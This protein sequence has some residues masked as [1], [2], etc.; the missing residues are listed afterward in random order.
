[1]RPLPSLRCHFGRLRPRRGPGPVQS[2]ARESRG[3][4]DRRTRRAALRVA[5]FVLLA[6][7]LGGGAEARP[8]Y[9]VLF[10]HGL[11]SSADVW[12]DVVSDLEDLGFVRG[13]TFDVELGQSQSLDEV[14]ID[15]APCAGMASSCAGGD[16]WRMNFDTIDDSNKAAVYLQA[17]AIQL[18]VE[19]LL[20]DLATGAE[21]VLLVGHSMGG[22]AASA[23]ASGV[24]GTP[25]DLGGSGFGAAERVVRVVT[26]GSPFGGSGLANWE[27]LLGG[28]PFVDTP[29][30]IRDLAKSSPS[31]SNV[32]LSGGLEGDVGSSFFSQDV[33]CDGVEEPTQEIVGLLELART[34]WPPETEI[35]NVVGMTPDLDFV[36]DSDCVVKSEDQALLEVAVPEDEAPPFPM[37][38]KVVNAAHAENAFLCAAECWMACPVVGCTETGATNA[39]LEALD[40]SNAPAVPWL[41]RSDGPTT[42]FLTRYDH[43]GADHDYFFFSVPAGVG[44][45]QATLSFPFLPSGDPFLATG[46]GLR[47]YDA[48]FQE[49]DAAFGS[50]GVLTVEG[51]TSSSTS[52]PWLVRVE[53]TVPT[54]SASSPCGNN[55][56]TCREPYRVAVTT[57]GIGASTLSLDATPDAVEPGQPSSLLAVVRASGGQPVASGIEVQ[58]TASGG[59]SG[60]NGTPTSCTSTTNAAGEATAN[61]TPAFVGSHV[62]TATAA[63]G[64]SDTTTVIAASGGLVVNATPNPVEVDVPSTIDVTASRGDGSPAPSGQV[65]TFSTT[66]PGLFSGN[67]ASSS[68]SPSSVQIDG[69]GSTWIRFTPTAS[70]VAAITVE[71]DGADAAILQL[72]AVA[73]SN[74][75]QVQLSVGYTGGSETLAEYELEARV[76]DDDGEPIFGEPVTFTTT[77]GGLEGTSAQSVTR[78]TGPTGVADAALRVTEEVLVTV[79]A[80]A[81]GVTSATS[82]TVQLG[83]VSAEIF[84]VRTLTGF[85][86]DVYGVE[87]SPDGSLLVAADYDGNVR[88][89]NTSG[90]SLRWS[91]TTDDDRA[92]QVSF[93]PSGTKVLVGHDDAVDVFSATNGS[94]DCSASLGGGSGEEAVSAVF[95]SD[96]AF[97]H[98]SNGGS[99]TDPGFYRHGSLC[100]SGSLER[101][102]ANGDYFNI[103]AHMDY[104]DEHNWVAIGSDDGELYVLDASTGSTVHDGSI[105]SG[106][107]EAYDVDFSTDSSRLL[108]V[109]WQVIKVFNTTSWSTQSF[110]APG[111]GDDHYGAVFLDADS[112][113]AIGGAGKI[114]ILSASVGTT[115][116]TGTV[117][118]NAWEMAWSSALERLAVGT[119][120]GQVLVFDP[121]APLDSQPPIISVFAPSEGSSTDEDSVSTSGSVTDATAVSSFTIDGAPVSLDATGNF[122]T[123]VALDPGSNSITYA[124]SDPAGN[125]SEVTRNVTRLIDE[126]PPIVFGVS[127]APPS[128][129]AGFVVE[130][131]ADAE[132][133]DTGVASVTAF[134]EDVSGQVV[135]TLPMAARSPETYSATYSTSGRNPGTYTVDIEAVDSSPQANTRTLSPAGSFVVESPPDLDVTPLT[136]NFGSVLVGGTAQLAFQ[137]RNLGGGSLSG[138]ATTVP[139]FVVVSGSPFTLGGGA[140]TIVAVE[141]RPVAAGESAGTLEFTGAGQTISVGLSGA[142]YLPPA[143]LDPSVTWLD[144]GQVELFTCPQHT[145]V[146]YNVGG[147]ELAG[148]ASASS[149]FGIVGD[150]AYTI[151]AGASAPIVVEFCPSLLGAV[152]GALEL[153]G[154]GG[155]VVELRG[156]GWVPGLIF[157]SG[158]ESGAVSAWS[159]ATGID[160]SQISVAETSLDFGVIEPGSTSTGQSVTI[161]N[162]GAGPL[163]GVAST[164]PPFSVDSGTPYSLYP[165]ES[166]EVRVA[167]A[168]TSPGTYDADL[169]LTGGGGASV[170]LS[171]IGQDSSPGG[172]V[173]HFRFDGNGAD[174]SPNGHDASPEAVTWSPGVL[175][176]AVSFSTIED[177][178][179]T[180]VVLDVARPYTLAFWLR[181]EGDQVQRV[182]S[183]L[184][185]TGAGLDVHYDSADEPPMHHRLYSAG[186]S[187]VSADQALSLEEWQ[188]VAAVW[189]GTTHAS[190]YLNGVLTESAPVSGEPTTSNESVKIGALG[191]LTGRHEDLVGSVD[192]LYIYDRVLS[193]SEISDLVHQVTELAPAGLYRF[194]EGAGTVAFDDSENGNDGSLVLGATW[195]NEGASGS[196]VSFGGDARVDV[197]ASLFSGLGGTAYAR[198]WVRLDTLPL[199]FSAG[200]VYRRAHYNDFILAVNQDGS[201]R[202]D[203][204]SEDFFTGALATG[205][206]VPVGTWKKIAVWYDGTALRVFI[207]DVEAG[208][209][210]VDLTMAWPTN[211]C[212]SPIP[213]DHERGC[214]LGTSVGGSPVGNGA[215]WTSLP[216]S[217][218]EVCIADAPS[219][220]GDDVQLG[221][222]RN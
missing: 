61:F 148:S 175:G 26:L 29:N 123:T 49:V 84:P 68:T 174:S 199:S 138:T 1:M 77:H 65:V 176:Q 96:S 20:G 85:T 100:G 32:F 134:V 13:G 88:A 31:H 151:A 201:V 207:D 75:I 208:S 144:F 221:S 17:G 42:G 35:F 113:I 124:A 104:S 184:S 21:R 129:Q 152:T 162:T 200:V 155:G 40:E 206:S 52:D 179:D 190:L 167:F 73:P 171:G 111:L 70:G 168:P 43:T 11:N 57:S 185:A 118:G 23:F 196:A 109:G 146:L 212:S 132:D 28:L 202:G 140:S 182:V 220:C 157:F 18:A 62:V 187:V 181:P 15:P 67:G 45:V 9:P 94:R 217:V 7:T 66:H 205:G 198:A 3:I 6:A 214:Y 102:L 128:G 47:L 33:D 163:H 173:A 19:F 54:S 89:W 219:D 139:P 172:L 36:P 82:F 2:T 12:D 147:S 44:Q 153:T 210:A 131:R 137:V 8:P 127:I 50:S 91:T 92:S 27:N 149:P 186:V 95:V 90:W 14:V 203:A 60:C 78:Q 37:P 97:F 215:G 158:F 136:G 30:A 114:E 106:A 166:I 108:A 39:I 178:V 5:V 83:T 46:V 159:S 98:V 10:V 41:L 56:P 188:H 76:L 116:R 154:G 115:V 101:T 209:Q 197:P 34:Q 63:T 112:K 165:G 222:P 74:A 117:S 216:G 125:S 99:S 142:G 59:L 55:C 211:P 79:T 80:T 120:S 183:A 218:D 156:S 64:G 170:R 4:E 191:T 110:N 48:D 86:D 122:S 107:N 119:S 126:T 81:R 145:V 22:L 103:A 58:F 180:N 189:D 204:W 160:L 192:E 87:F 121:L 135:A 161:S 71:T 193:D 141:F 25:P 53:G 133:G 213:G 150:G 194:D 105:V 72:D 177:Y 38:T 16:L 195:T 69:T 51:S 130:I 169:L 143:V 24:I 93:N 164:T